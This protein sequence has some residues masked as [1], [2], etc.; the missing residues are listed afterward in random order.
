[1]CQ[2]VFDLEMYKELFVLFCGILDSVWDKSYVKNL[3]QIW[4]FF[5]LLDHR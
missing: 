2:K 5:P 4:E 1:M 3:R